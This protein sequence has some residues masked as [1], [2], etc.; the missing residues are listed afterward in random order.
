MPSIP[1]AAQAIATRYQVMVDEALPG[2]LEGLY[3]VGS[4]ALHDYM[5]GQSDEDFIAVTATALDASEF[6]VMKK[7]HDRLTA[8]IPR[9]WFS[10]IYV[11]WSDLACNP[12]TIERVPFY[13]EGRFGLGDGFDAN[14]PNWLTLRNYP[15]SLRSPSAPDVW[16][17]PVCLHRWTLE[18][19]HS[20]WQRYMLRHRSLHG[21][22]VVM[23]ADR[24]I[25]W[26]VLGITRL[27]YTLST[28]DI[29]SKS[30][31]CRYGLERFPRHWHAVL[32]DALALRTGEGMSRRNRVARRREALDFMQ[33]V[34]DNSH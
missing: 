2:R 21:R 14:P 26:C 13:L 11:T 32:R 12:L 34:I 3:L 25:V 16:H 23:L 30:N 24:A 29:T 31:A 22:G 8:Q 7:V 28:G 1:E 9:P 17:D 6:A 15:V 10:G 20:Y 5:P 18:N 4:I 19:L 33:F 27:H